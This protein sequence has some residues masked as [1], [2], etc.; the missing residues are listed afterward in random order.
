[1]SLNVQ[2][3]NSPES[4]KTFS[5]R[6]SWYYYP[7][8]I[9]IN[10]SSPIYDYFNSSHVYLKRKYSDYSN[11]Y[12]TKSK[13]FLRKDAIT[14]VSSNS[15]SDYSYEEQQSYPIQDTQTSFTTTT[16][17]TFLQFT[18]PIN[19]YQLSNI[20]NANPS[21]TKINEQYVT[22]MYGRKGWICVL[23]ENFNYITRKKCNK[24]GVQKNPKK[25][26]QDHNTNNKNNSH[27]QNYIETNTS[28]C[29]LSL[30]TN[31]NA[32]L[33]LYGNND[34]NKN[35]LQSNTKSNQ[36]YQK[37]WVCFQCKNV[38][39]S[40][41]VICNRCELPKVQSETLM[42]NSYQNVI[43]NNILLNNQQQRNLF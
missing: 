12:F 24:C 20:N 40:F 17:Q 39:F 30:S 1:M 25:I 3:S 38:N 6:K 33:H 14:D 7:R 5:L 42:V 23:C 21:L 35:N 10:S 22:E 18:P 43:L 36:Q 29:P 26:T 37:D 19:Q 9:R 28:T 4:N 8:P 2:Y 32:D 41:R 27:N 34:K 16:S 15:Q 13:I 11:T 31:Q